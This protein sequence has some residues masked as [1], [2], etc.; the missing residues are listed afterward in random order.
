MV[1]LARMLYGSQN[2]GL[3]GKDSDRDY[4][5]V[6]CPE[7]A[8][9]YEGRTCKHNEGE[10]VTGIDLRRLHGLLINGNPN[11]V[12]LLYSV[13]SYELDEYMGRYMDALRMMYEGGYVASVWRTFYAALTG[14]AL[15]AIGRNGVNPKTVSRAFYFLELAKHLAKNGFVIN[16][17]VYRGMGCEFHQLARRLRFDPPKREE[18]LRQIADDLKRG[19]EDWKNEGQNRADAACE[20]QNWAKAIKGTD[21]LVRAIVWNRAVKGG[22]G[23]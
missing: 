23:V 8:E 1:E 9:L 15:N 16:E 5:A 11:A 2:Y 18:V 21:D 6:L 7:F 3:D 22:P 17:G 19:F 20:G 12:E 4:K 14:L 10:H 13:E